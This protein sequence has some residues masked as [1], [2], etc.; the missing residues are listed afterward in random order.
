MPHASASGIHYT[1]TQAASCIT[2]ACH[3]FCPPPFSD[4][5]S[6]PPRTLP[7]CPTKSSAIFNFPLSIFNSPAHG[8]RQPL[9]GSPLYGVKSATC[10]C[11]YLPTPANL[12]LQAIFV[13][14]IGLPA[15]RFSLRS[16]RRS[17]PAGRFNTHFKN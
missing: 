10:L 2:L 11:F 5:R 4:S 1:A 13:F 8:V 15:L 17:H 14:Y 7:S 3:A 9:Y 12:S 6:P 16:I